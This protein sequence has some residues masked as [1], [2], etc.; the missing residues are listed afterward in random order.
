MLSAYLSPNG[1]QS[2]EIQKSGAPIARRAKSANAPQVTGL[3]VQPD[4]IRAGVRLTHAQWQATDADGDKL[5]TKVDYSTD[6]G[7]TWKPIFFGPNVNGA[8]LASTHFAKSAAG[9]IRVRVSDGFNETSAVSGAFS[10]AGS[11][12]TALIYHPQPGET[13]QTGKNVQLLGY[14]FDTDNQPIPDAGL[15]WYDG[16]TLLGTGKG[17][18]VPNL[19]PGSHTFRLDATDAGGTGSRKVT[20]LVLK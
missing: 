16:D 18:T 19:A 7:Q 17:I 6:N 1:V 14:A 2:L 3:L 11:P 15:K 10:A 8:D 20:V 9:L 13:I 4:T 5:M 12:P